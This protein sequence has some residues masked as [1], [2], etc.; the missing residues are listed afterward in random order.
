MGLQKKIELSA[1]DLGQGVP[2]FA[3]D[4]T[5]SKMAV[6]GANG[7]VR[8]ISSQGK[9]LHTFSLPEVLRL[10]WDA[11]GGSLALIQKGSSNVSLMLGKD[12]GLETVDTGLEGLCFIAWSPAAAHL[13]VGSVKGDI[14]IINSETKKKVSIAGTH[15][16]RIIDGGWTIGNVFVAASEDQVLSVSD[17]GG[18]VQQQHTIKNVPL[19]MSLIDFNHGDESPS[20]SKTV[21][22]VNGGS[23]LEH[24]NLGGA[25]PHVLSFDGKLGTITVCKSLPSG[26]TCVGFTSGALALVQINA[27]ESKVYGVT[28]PFEVAVRS[29]SCCASSTMCVAVAGS[30]LKL[31][32]LADKRI[33]E[34]KSDS[35]E[36][37]SALGVPQSVECSKNGM[38]ITVAT[39]Q[40]CLISY[41]VPVATCSVVYGQNLYSLTSA[42]TVSVRTL[43]EDRTLYTVALSLD[44]TI[45]A[46]SQ[47]ILGAC[48]GNTVLYFKLGG[49]EGNQINSVTYPSAVSVL[50]VSNTH[51]AALCGGSVQLHEVTSSDNIITLPENGDA[52][53]VSIG[54]SDSLFMYATQEKIFLIN[55]ADYQCVVEHAPTSGIK[56][57]FP[58][59]SCTRIALID[60]QDAMCVLNPVTLVSTQTE[61]FE[62]GHKEIMW[63]QGDYGVLVSYNASTM[64]T[65]VYAPHS[66]YGPTVES[67]VVKESKT[68]NMIT[69][70]PSGYTPLCLSKGV[71]SLQGSGN[72]IEALTLAS[73]NGA[74]SRS[75]NPEAFYNNFSLNHLR[76][77]SQNISTTQ[78]AEDLAVKALHMLDVELAIRLYRQLSQP[79][80]VMYIESI[81]HINEKNLLIGHVSMIMGYFKDAQNF[82]LRSSQP[83]C[84]LQMRHNLMQ[85]EPALALAKQLAP[86]KL[87]LLS[88]EYA[89]Q[90]EYRGEYANALEMYRAG[91]MPLPKGHASTE[92][93]A[94]VAEVKKHNDDCLQG[95]ARCLLRTGGV[96]EGVKLAEQSNDLAFTTECAEILESLRHYDE[97]AHLYEKALNFE[98]AAKLYIVDARNLKAAS[99]IIPRITSR[100]IIGMYAKGKEGEG[101]FTEAEKAYTQAEDW[102]NV[103]RIKV[104]KLNNLQGAYD[105]VRQTRSVAAASVVANMCKRRGEFAVAVEFF[106][107][108]KAFAEGFEL[109]KE[110]GCM[111]SLESALLSQVQL[112]DGV[113]PPGSQEEFSVIARHYEQ[114]NKPGQAGLFYHIAGNFPLALKNYLEAGQA[115]DIEK[116]I[117][118]VGKSRSDALTTKLIDYLMGEADGE[119]KE[120]S[121][122]FKLY[123]ALGSYEKAAKTSVLI[124]TKEQDM[125]SY[126]AAHRTLVEACRILREKKMRVP[127]D[128]RRSLMLLHSYVIVKHL[129]KVMND[130][131][132]A[133]RMLLR[134]V[135]NIQRFPQHISTLYTSTALQ[136]LKSGFKKSAFDNACIIIQNERYRTELDDKNR[137]KI[138]SIVRR[139]GKEELDDPPES[140]APCPFCDAEVL[141]TEL[142]CG[143]CKNTLPFC[144]VTGKHMVKQ[145]YSE[146]PICHF[147]ALY[148][149][150]ITL[151][152]QSQVCPMCEN[153]VDLNEVK[154][155]VDPDFKTQLL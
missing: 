122:I 41:K 106:V 14:V 35:K 7:K 112:T 86:E 131:E 52:E 47:D 101:A 2:C 83:L 85:W 37:D 142:E 115:E 152:R 100:N 16:K 72:T 12:G 103:V 110:K 18:N 128:L 98:H 102:D 9:A 143:S 76:W 71:V 79:S 137:K 105:I 74:T 145:N 32:S 13:A 82:F 65:Y 49:N 4:A 149:S 39:D 44:P 55:L 84:A 1:K 11:T 139:R 97:A 66:R 146:C 127:N 107:L 67:V 51:A 69:K 136:C 150:F 134:V 114:D 8:I 25:K 147:P 124:A 104:E 132:T 93:T 17:A 140:T 64:A 77:A 108:A 89:Q 63:D 59:F 90:L 29:M 78:E 26:I 144:I 73:H 155:H 138:E 129:I 57:A 15:T 28:R 61:G 133:S 56:K 48:S 58:N 99:L 119:P 94:A 31:F 118:V 135:R 113:A 126:M 95:A 20:L 3:W 24:F 148:T 60:K 120:P 123:M 21:T 70:I 91:E 154:K 33:T 109:A 30:R 50:K 6:S 88:K 68:T 125:G 42:R 141:E 75:P 23:V 151:L 19:A 43:K 130:D 38:D 10:E 81:K 117:E 111:T 80:L 121:Y 22:L 34:S 87:P 40:S 5:S 54:I 53:V 45:L 27:Q 36:L 96:Q 153:M 92:F 116:A 46:A 62:Q